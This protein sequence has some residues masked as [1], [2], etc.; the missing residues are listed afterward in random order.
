MYRFTF[1]KL[2]WLLI[3]FVCESCAQKSGEQKMIYL[4]EGYSEF[5]YEIYEPN[6]KYILKDKLREISALTFYSEDKLLCVNDEKGIIYKYHLRKREVTKTY[7]FDRSGDYEGIEMIDSLVYVLRSDGKIFKVDHLKEKSIN[8]V[9]RNTTLNASNDTEGLGYDPVSNSLLVAC[10]G[11][12]G[13]GNHLRGKRAIYRFSIDKNELESK[14]AYLI[15]QEQ[16]RKI[17]EF[18]GY[19]RFSVKL[20]ESVNPAQGDV[21]FQPSAIAIHPITKNLYVVGSVGKLLLVLNPK[22]EI[23]AVVKLKRK[24][25]RQPEGI[26]F[27]PDGTMYISNEGKGSKANILKFKMKTSK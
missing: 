2:C 11:S 7:H 19:A 26:C 12:P 4:S 25:F 20:L 9:K 1:P 16:I 10:K 13:K 22:G 17:L 5:P 15:D 27:A 23:Q 6:D 14:P 21:T 24:I 8:S 3:L 18:N